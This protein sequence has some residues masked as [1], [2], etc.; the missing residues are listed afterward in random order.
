MAEFE[1]AE[2]AFIPDP[3][4]AEFLGPDDPDVAAGL[5]VD[6]TN[7]AIRFITETGLRLS[8]L[9]MPSDPMKMLEALADQGVEGVVEIADNG[10]IT[11]PDLPGQSHPLA[12]MID[13][14]VTSDPGFGPGLHRNP[15]GDGFHYLVDAI[16]NTQRIHPTLPEP[17]ELVSWGELFDVV[18]Q[19]KINGSFSVVL[20]GME[21]TLKPTF[22]VE[23]RTLAEDEE[24]TPG[25]GTDSNGKLA[26][27]T[28]QDEK[29]VVTI[30]LM[31][32]DPQGNELDL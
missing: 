12:F 17:A 7:G 30:R 29:T 9:P 2:F 31:L 3:R 18:I 16:G 14:M 32:I 21:F 26:F 10:V 4:N 15:Q 20:E 6:P 5:S 8:L 13:L 1:G 24:V 22:D 27:V 23:T 28:T 19:H 25:V 11:V